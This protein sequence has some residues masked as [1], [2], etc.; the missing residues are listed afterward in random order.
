MSQ[1]L[2]HWRNSVRITPPL[3]LTDEQIQAY[4]DLL[5][6]D[7]PKAYR[8]CP[9][10][11]FRYWEIYHAE[12][13]PIKFTDFEPAF[14]GVT[15]AEAWE[16]RGYDEKSGRG[17]LLNADSVSFKKRSV[18]FLELVASLREQKLQ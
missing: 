4:L 9:M 16:P 10:E 12:G 6:T 2:S 1:N 14:R 8:T 3:S 11:L 18:D 15:D 13:C 5:K 7:K 17:P